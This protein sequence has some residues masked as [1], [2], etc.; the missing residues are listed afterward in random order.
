MSNRTGKN[1][2][3]PLPESE[4]I[5]KLSNEFADHFLEKIQMVRVDL[6]QHPKYQ[7]D[8]HD[9]PKLTEFHPMSKK[10]ILKIMNEMLTKYCEL[11]AI[12][13]A[14]LKKLAPYI[15][16][17]ITRIVNVSLTEGKFPSQ[18][19]IASIRPLLKKLG[20]ELLAKN[21]RP[22]N[23]LSFL[24]KLIE[25]CMLSQFNSHCKLN[26]LIPTYQSAYRAFHRTSCDGFKCSL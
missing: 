4:N 22:V 7:P 19:R 12:P 17:I 14:I 13:T 21:Y 24:S 8:R 23:N 2:E 5:E 1:T 25:K 16:E 9:V 26:G 3:N 20:L 11:D 18:W 6:D 15:R 10:E